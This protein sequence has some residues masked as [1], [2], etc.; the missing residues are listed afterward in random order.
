MDD[1][2]IEYSS[3]LWYNIIKITV[4][5]GDTKMKSN[6]E[7]TVIQ[8]LE[9]ETIEKVKSAERKALTRKN[10]LKQENAKYIDGTTGQT[11]DIVAAKLNMSGKHWDRMKYIYNHKNECNQQEY[12]D[13]NSGIISTSK[14]YSKLKNSVATSKE[15]DI[16]ID[17]LT[18][19]ESELLKYMENLEIQIKEKLDLYPQ[20]KERIYP[21]LDEFKKQFP[22]I[23]HSSYS[24]W[25]RHIKIMRLEHLN[26]ILYQIERIKE[27]LIEN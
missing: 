4:I 1:Y 3:Q 27:N 8:G 13:W 2:I 16:L 5:Q 15:I 18:V 22:I 9:L 6:R 21:L 23:E 11:R 10:G 17:M 20:L 12:E 24:L 19:F 25:S 14:L 26:K 7:Q